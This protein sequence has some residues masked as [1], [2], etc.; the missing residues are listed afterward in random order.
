MALFRPNADAEEI[1]SW[2]DREFERMHTARLSIERQ[3]LLNLSFNK[4]KHWV[5]WGPAV[6]Q[7]RRLEEPKN[8]PPWRIRLTVNKVQP[9]IRREMARLSSQKPRGYVLPRSQEETDRHAARSALSILDFLHEELELDDVHDLADWWTCITGSSFY[10]VRWTEE[11]DPETN[12]PGRLRCDVI[13]PFDFYVSDIEETRI[14]EQ[15][16]VCQTGMLRIGEIAEKWGVDVAADGYSSDTDQRVRSV[17]SVFNQEKGDDFAVVK[18]FWIKR[19]PRYPNGLVLATCNG[20]LLPYEPQ[21]PSDQLLQSDISAEVDPNEQLFRALGID[22]GKLSKLNEEGETGVSLSDV[23]PKRTAEH[24]PP[25]TIEFPFGHGRLPFI[26][27]G[28]TKSGL[29]YD[30]SFV[31]QIIPLQREYNRSRSQI[32]ENKNLTSRPQW[33]I[34]LGAV[35]RSELTTEPGA[36]ISYSPGF[37]PPEP[38][39]PPQLPNYVVD[40]VRLTAEE[41]DELASQ[42]DV[43]KGD[44]PPNVEAATAIA[45]LQEKDDAAV[46]YAVRSKERA[47]QEISIQLLKLVQEFWTEERLIR[48]VGT[49]E[50]F[51]AYQFKGSQ[52]RGNT[53]YRVVPG[54]GLP[55]SRA[56]QE[57]KLMQMMET[58]MIPVP[59]GLRMMDMPDV[60]DVVR[61]Y[62][63]D[64][65]EA[66]KENLVMSKGEYA[67]VYV[68]QDHV[69]HLDEHDK[70]KKQEQYKHLND[71]AKKIFDFHDY[72]HLQQLAQLFNLMPPEDP[73]RMQQRMA[74][75]QQDPMFVD[76]A[77]A[78]L[79]RTIFIQLKAGVAT[80]AP[81]PTNMPAATGTEQGNPPA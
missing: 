41:M 55:R 64:T 80:P 34:P 19:C 54:S 12:Q 23:E 77:H 66:D 46:G 45:Y 60:A 40:H 63:V 31:E 67:Q 16:F 79:L 56:A 8:Q 48:V 53:D 58:G 30:T 72:M 37:S 78:F 28:H 42:N 21:D 61:D 52:L 29:F 17:M 50:V 59:A 33:A 47:I 25:G 44:V 70:F 5:T 9:Y 27:R 43:S 69:A 24:I 76:P 7:A 49:N 81:P 13:R 57:A 51:D 20:M 68:W 32:V 14:K 18:E 22:V 71:E 1:A 39:K 73:M 4:G 35:N 11:L 3:W 15:E 38:I 65:I 6:N 10:K 2:A 74:A 75:M 62:E 26:P 36:V